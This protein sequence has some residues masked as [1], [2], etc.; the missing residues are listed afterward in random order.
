MTLYA[1]VAMAQLL[2]VLLLLAPATPG[3]SDSSLD[4]DQ[5]EEWR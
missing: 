2:L 1:T 4:V 5:A 3:S